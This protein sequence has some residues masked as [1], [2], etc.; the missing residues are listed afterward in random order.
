[1]QIIEN[2][3]VRT[4]LMRRYL[5]ILILV[6]FSFTVS[7]CNEE[8]LHLPEHSYIQGCALVHYAN[9]IELYADT[10]NVMFD[11]EWTLI[12]EEQI[13]EKDRAF[14][15]V[16]GTGTGR[17][18]CLQYTEWVIE[19][20]DGNGDTRHFV[21]S[22]RRGFYSY[23]LPHISGIVTEYYWEHFVTVYMGIFRPSSDN[24]NISTISICGK[25]TSVDAE[26]LFKHQYMKS[27]ATPEGA[28]RL[29][30]FTP[31]NVFEIAPFKLS[32]FMRFDS[33]LVVIDDIL[34]RVDK[35][36]DAMNDFT[37]QSLNA[38]IVVR[39]N[40]RDFDDHWR[41]Y[42]QGERVW[43]NNLSSCDGLAIFDSYIGVLW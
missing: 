40:R 7:A 15:Q 38:E 20:K 18:M 25:C 9:Y 30:Q 27:L 14:V 37:N 24:F 26:I 23:I 17:R 34:T 3:V 31:A 36:V 32:A 11:N 4:I 1:M 42:V 29:S 5:A 35:M 21:F 39:D 13:H 41:G 10:L 16:L 2:L 28:I 12:S 33:D 19:Y 6:A 8:V 22:N 43:I